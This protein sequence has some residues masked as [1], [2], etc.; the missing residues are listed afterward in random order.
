[1][2][3]FLYN[4]IDGESQKRCDFALI[5]LASF[6]SSG[7]TPSFKNTIMGTIHEGPSSTQHTSSTSGSSMLGLGR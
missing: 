6:F 5:L 4:A 2:K 1:M 7:K 3:D